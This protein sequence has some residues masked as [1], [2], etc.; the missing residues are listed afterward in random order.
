M[1]WCGST[2]ANSDLSTNF[3]SIFNELYEGKYA[4]GEDFCAALDALYK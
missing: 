1:S 2:N 4:T 3:K